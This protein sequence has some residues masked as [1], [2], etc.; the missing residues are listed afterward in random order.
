MEEGF[1]KRRPS[2]SPSRWEKTVTSPYGPK[3]RSETSDNWRETTPARLRS[4]ISVGSPE[5]T[6][7]PNADTSHQQRVQR[8]Q[9]IMVKYAMKSFNDSFRQLRVNET[10]HVTLIS[11]AVIEKH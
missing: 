8:K 6:Y 1:G 10:H 7:K 3:Q 9:I 11:N 5:I 2:L 4:V